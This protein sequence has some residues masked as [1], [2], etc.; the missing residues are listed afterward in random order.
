[1]MNTSYNDIKNSDD[2]AEALK[3]AMKSSIFPQEVLKLN[4][5]PG[6]VFPGGPVCSFQG[7]SI[8]AL[9]VRWSASGGITPE[10][11]V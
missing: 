1:M 6:K 4:T 7:K 11:L 2:R 10:I 9:F 3:V 5:G 8:P